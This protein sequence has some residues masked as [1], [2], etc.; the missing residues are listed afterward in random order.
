[1]QWLNWRTEDRALDL[2]KYRC[3]GASIALFGMAGFYLRTLGVV[4]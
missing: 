2:K 3:R 4:V 1:M